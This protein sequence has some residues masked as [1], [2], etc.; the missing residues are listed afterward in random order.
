VVRRLRDSRGERADPCGRISTWVLTLELEV[1]PLVLAAPPLVLAVPPG[2][3]SRVESSAGRRKRPDSTPCVLGDEA[4]VST[5]V[6]NVL[7]RHHCPVPRPGCLAADLPGVAAAVS[8]SALTPR[9]CVLTPRI[10]V[11]TARTRACAGVGRAPARLRVRQ[12]QRRSITISV[13]VM[14]QDI[15]DESA[16]GHR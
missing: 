14:S 10:C 8:T 3:E 16:S 6:L 1:P 15:G 4:Q 9:T 5:C 13:G 11:L 12:G 2:L 7:A